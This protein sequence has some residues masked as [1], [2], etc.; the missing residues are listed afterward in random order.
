MLSDEG[1]L[2]K[3]HSVVSLKGL[4]DVVVTTQRTKPVHSCIA[5]TTTTLTADGE[6]LRCVLGGVCLQPC[7]KAINSSAT[8]RCEHV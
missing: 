8:T 1:H 3:E 5:M 4:E 2:L 7:G 6:S